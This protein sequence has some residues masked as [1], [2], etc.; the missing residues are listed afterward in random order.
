MYEFV[1]FMGIVEF[2]DPP[3]PVP[4]RQCAKYVEPHFF[5]R[6][7]TRLPNRSVSERVIKVDR[8]FDAR[9]YEPS[10]F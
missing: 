8:S 4:N 10:L 3:Y 9:K 6:P 2:L 5:T 7:D 1:K